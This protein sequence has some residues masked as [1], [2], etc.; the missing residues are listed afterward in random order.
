MLQNYII[1]A[2]RNFVRHGWMTLI[3]VVGLV[4]GLTVTIFLFQYVS[5]ELG[6]DRF[7]SKADRTYRLTNDRFQDGKRIHHGVTTYPAVGPALVK[8]YPQIEA[9]SRTMLGFGELNVKIGD[10]VQA[11]GT[12]LFVDSAFLSVFDFELVA[13]DRSTALRDPFQIVL[14]ESQALHYFELPN[15]DFVQLLGKQLYFSDSS[16][17]YLVSGICRD[18]PRNSHLA[19]D[20]LVSYSTLITRFPQADDSWTWSDMRHYIVLTDGTTGDDFKK[21]LDDFTVRYFKGTAVTGSKEEFSLQPLNDIHLHSDFE[22]DIARTSSYTTVMGMLIAAILI[23]GLAWTNY[24]NLTV[25]YSIKRTKEIGLRKVMGASR[26]QVSRQFLAESLLMIGVC[27]A[28]STVAVGVLQPSFN[29]LVDARLSL[30]GMISGMGWQA[31]LVFGAVVSLSV[32]VSAAYPGVV[33]SSLPPVAVVRNAGKNP[34]ARNL[35]RLVVVIQFF[36]CAMLLFS[37]LVISSQLTF[38]GT[39]E[40]GIDINNTIVIKAP[41][42]TRWDSTFTT[43]VETFREEMP[44]VNGVKAVAASNKLPGERLPRIFKVHVKGR[45]TEDYHTLSTVGVGRNF[46]ELYNVRLAAGRTFIQEDYKPTWNEINNLIINESGSLKLGFRDAESALG[47]EVFL[48]NRYFTVV[49]VVGDF[50]QESLKAER[51]PMLFRPAFGNGQSFSIKI[52]SRAP[53]IVEAASA[54]FNRIFPH[55]S[56]DY[57]FLEDRFNSRYDGD[58]RFDRVIGIFSMLAIIIAALGLVA[59]TSHSTN[60]RTKEIGIRKVLGASVISIVYLFSSGFLR[61]VVVALVLALPVA[62]LAMNN[63]LSSYAYHVTP[64]VISFILPSVGL[65][66]IALLAIST[67]VVRKATVSPCETMKHE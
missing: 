24:I 67:Q 45:P 55:N 46:F 7:H 22:Y 34:F 65:I 33:L 20:A 42:R 37:S 1:I 60:E 27:I 32:I 51:E 11:G 14:T 66:L 38:L 61:L 39:A 28:L 30:T 17:P 43:R 57:Y 25:A 41:T 48:E 54:V 6:F 4:A 15:R 58:F 63:W 18:A 62:Y 35:A 52:D 56:F 29:E 47:Q 3:N 13:G 40:L 9:Y 12:Y 53:E 10:D 49:G 16:R 31:F 64:G 19:F 59:L 26:R 44:K 21:D 8:D 50:H 2:A 5:F 23:L 36:V